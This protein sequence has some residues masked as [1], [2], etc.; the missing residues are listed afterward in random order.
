[1][2]PL[3]LLLMHGT[4]ILLTKFGS[5][6]V[7]FHLSSFL[8]HPIFPVAGSS[9]RQISGKGKRSTSHATQP[10]KQQRTMTACFKSN[11]PF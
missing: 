5:Y 3:I 4:I 7:F 11:F 10:P 8:I 2:F 1:M 9:K 6:I